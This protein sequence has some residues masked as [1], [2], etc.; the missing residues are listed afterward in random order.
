MH[1]SNNLPQWL[2][3]KSPHRMCHDRNIDLRCCSSHFLA[4]K[5]LPILNQHMNES[6]Q[7]GCH[8]RRHRMPSRPIPQGA[9]NFPVRS[10]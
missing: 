8:R 10:A 9:L 7:M 2:S 1:N 5:A 4:A 6:V 3:S